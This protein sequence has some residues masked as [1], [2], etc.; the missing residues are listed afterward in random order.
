MQ[1]RSHSFCEHSAFHP[2][3]IAFVCVV[4]ALLS[5][6]T[7]LAGTHWPTRS[8]DDRVEPI[9]APNLAAEPML[10][11]DNRFV[12]SVEPDQATDD[13]ETKDYF[14]LRSDVVAFGGPTGRY[15]SPA[16]RAAIIPFRLLAFSSRGSPS[17]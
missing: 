15:K 5:G 8:V 12:A 14:L 2:G 17:L 13:D 16:D 6:G 7:G 3:L 10:S 4:M 9:E 11:L 1:R